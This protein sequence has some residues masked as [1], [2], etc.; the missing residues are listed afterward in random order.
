MTSK[1][2][3]QYAD[4]SG[5][6]STSTFYNA[7]LNAGGTN[8]PTIQTQRDAL[9][10]ALNGI[11]LA[12]LQKVGNQVAETDVSAT[13]PASAQAQR[14]MG[15]LLTIADQVG[16]KFQ[17]TI[18]APDLETIATQG[19]DIV[20]L[21]GTEMAALVAA[22]EGGD[23]QNPNTQVGVGQVLSAR[24]VGRRN[25]EYARRQVLA[26]QKNRS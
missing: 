3:F 21:A 7:D 25:Y 26:A 14:E 12:S 20:D 1:F 9:R 4:Y 13:L 22:L 19:T 24:I 2:T 23:W 16:F 5:E 17:V 6:K 18:P 11:T 15:L 8:W 10:D